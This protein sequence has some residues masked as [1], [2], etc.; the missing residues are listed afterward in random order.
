MIKL[1]LGKSFSVIR[2]LS[3]FYLLIF[4]LIFGITFIYSE[5]IHESKLFF[6]YFKHYVISIS[7]IIFWIIVIFLKDETKK[8][9]V[10]IFT[11]ISIAIILIEILSFFY[12]S[13][14]KSKNIFINDLDSSTKKFDSK[15]KKDSNDLIIEGFDS[16]TKEYDSRTRK[17]VYDDFNK[18]NIEAVVVIQ[19]SKHYGEISD[20]NYTVYPLSGI[21]KKTTIFCNES[22][23]YSIYE[24]DRYGFNNPDIVWEKEL[25]DYMLV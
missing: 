21:S 11:S 19:P 8:I 5:I 13:Y 18:K 20:I 4:I 17:E 16:T 2:S 3:T 9:I 22:G 12:V 15:T 24:S 25:V 6:H 10:L 7:G 1:N 14:I 23:K